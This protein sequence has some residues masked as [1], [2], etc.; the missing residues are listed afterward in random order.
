MPGAI[1]ESML[2]KAAGSNK[3]D[4]IARRAAYQVRRD[5]LAEH[6]TRERY[7]DRDYFARFP[8]MLEIPRGKWTAPLSVERYSHDC[9]RI[10]AA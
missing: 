10:R 5:K 8:E 2:R 4:W 1:D 7:L 3:V 9:Y 6:R